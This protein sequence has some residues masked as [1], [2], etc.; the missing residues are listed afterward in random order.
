MFALINN[1]LLPIEQ[2]VVPVNDL[3]V[4]RG[5][6][7]FDFFRTH[8]GVPLFVEDHLKRLE[9]SAK[10]LHLSL[11]YSNTELQEQI[12]R[13]MQQH[14]LP[15]SGIRITVTG[16]SSADLYTPGTP[17]VIIT[18]HPL[19]MQDPERMH[20]GFRLITHEYVRELPEVKSIHYLMG[21]W[22]QPTVKAAGAD[23]ALYVKDG[24]ISELPRSNVFIIS[25]EGTLITPA[26]NILHGITREKV[27]SL[28]TE[29]LPVEIRPVQLDELMNAAEAFV[30]STTKRLIPI[31]S[32]N[33]KSIAK[34]TTG[35]I[36]AQLYER[37]VEMEQQYL[38]GN[39]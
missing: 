11:P 8:N 35:I 32:V 5:Y 14:Q 38:G 10:A 34:G 19:S 39:L 27:L 24:W 25:K 28:A 1:T 20:P 12:K 13:L 26:E 33:G 7:V 29:M 3:S 22:L 15:C 37:F 31:L 6:G 9:R 17:Q 21:V 16:G 23:D 4:Q 2:A 36:T 18:E 30:T